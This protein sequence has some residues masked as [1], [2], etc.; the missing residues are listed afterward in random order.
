MTTQLLIQIT[1][2]IILL[3]FSAF[4]S[5]SETALM[6]I[7]KIDVRHMVEQDI[8][9][10]KL[11]SRLLEDPNKMLGAILVGNNLVNIA[12][13]SLATVIAIDLFKDTASGL[14]IGIATGV[15]T[16]LI[17]VFGEITP[18]SL[19]NAHAHEV[20]IL[21]SKPI[22]LLVFLTNP[23]VKILM[24]TTHFIIKLF[25][26][27]ADESKPFIT[28]DELR[29]IVTVSHE[30]GVL[31]DEEKKMIYN[32]FD[33]GDSYAKDVMIPRT[34]MIAININ[35]TY[36]DI[37]N[38]YKEE[39]FSRMP[40]YEE[41]QDNII[42]ILYIKDLIIQSFDPNHF[43]VNAFLREVYFVHEYKRIDELFKEMRAQ[44]IGI[45]I[46]LDEYGG[47]SGLVTM[48]DLIE[49]IVGD[50]DDEYDITEDDI[51]QID[52]GEYLVD[53]TCRI[54][55]VNEYLSLD[56]TSQEFDSIGGFII[57]LLDRFPTEGEQVIY[58]TTTFIVEETSNNR[59]NKLRIFLKKENN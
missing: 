58:Q 28:A 47:T 35:D 56:I 9:G 7:S 32:V 16:L 26:G 38:L 59:I 33:F 49:E 8:K 12:A 54:S 44:K 13:S 42:G 11:L 22:L 10:A 17:L 43:K 29:T 34:D 19:S 23:I 24:G 57:G 36:E 1:I 41:S 2:L 6:S 25:G 52:D 53:A 46:V 5:A 30:E 51:I 40:V 27:N 48:E 39:H 50:I 20:A 55:E 14:G 3:G 4:F 31:E 18:K 37:L 15:M 21:V 45:A